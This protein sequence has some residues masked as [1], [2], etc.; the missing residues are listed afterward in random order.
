MELICQEVVCD[1]LFC[2]Q[3]WPR[4]ENWQGDK[5]NIVLQIMVKPNQ[6]SNKT[7]CTKPSSL[8]NWHPVGYSNIG[9]KNHPSFMEWF[10]NP[11]RE[12]LPQANEAKAKTE[13]N[14]ILPWNN[15]FPINIIL[16]K[17]KTI[18]YPVA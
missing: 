1:D 12:I 10:T 18:Y 13:M 2:S 15:V 17:K 7:S 11:V 5:G 8:A 14:M 3:G 9:F 6:N 16:K 4:M